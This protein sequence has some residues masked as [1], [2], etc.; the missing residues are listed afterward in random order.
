MPFDRRVWMIATALRQDGNDVT[1]I[2][3]TGKGFDERDEIID[4]I[5]VRRHPL[6]E[7]GRGLLGFAREYG[8]ALW[9]EMRLALAT[10]RSKPFDVVHI[11]NPPDL[12]FLVAGWFRLRHGTR[13]VYDQHDLV[14]G[15]YEAKYGRSGDLPH[16]ALLA[17]ERLS[18]AAADVVITTNETARE[19]AL[20]RGGNHPRETYV[21]GSGPDLEKFQPLPPR[22]ELRRG[23]R[24]LVGYVG[25]MGDQDGVD[26][27]VR[28]AAHIV[29][30]EQ[31]TDVQF[32]CLGGGPALDDLRAL[33]RTLDVEDFVDLPGLVYGDAMIE[34]LST[35]DV[36]VDPEPV[37]GYS[38]FCTTNKALEYMALAKPVVLFDRLEGRRSVGDAGA[39][40]EP[41][42]EVA[43]AKQLLAVLDDPGR[44]AEMGPAGL[45][46]MRD[47]LSWERQ[48]EHLL[49]AYTGV[50]A[51]D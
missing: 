17:M 13:I 48:R 11:C 5:H 33:A 49:E 4:G 19:V 30:V 21:V 23:R 14:P 35:A 22:P 20:G 28:A 42:D 29:H 45:A 1:V 15:M 44:R 40:A 24:H 9:W 6:P 34:A 39:Y 27:L 37:N 16:R 25:I 38:E 50:L 36:C 41:N 32:L 47:E 10:W 51:D 31:R 12:L 2:C 18:Y 8:A 26:H 3:P 46:R 43:L 7:E